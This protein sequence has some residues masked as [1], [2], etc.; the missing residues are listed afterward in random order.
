M[1]A[2]QPAPCLYRVGG[3][4]I[5]MNLAKGTGRDRGQFEA[6]WR[7][8]ARRWNWSKSKVGRFL[9]TLRADGMVCRVDRKSD[10]STERLTVSNYGDY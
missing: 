7:F 2:R 8:L 3:Q 1:V 10:R 9:S 4:D 5:V 6:S